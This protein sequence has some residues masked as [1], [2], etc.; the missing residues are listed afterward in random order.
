MKER[1]YGFL[2]RLERHTKVDMVYLSSG[3]FWSAIATVWGALI[4]LSTAAALANFLPKETYGTYQYVLTAATVIGILALPGTKTSISYAAARG[5]DGSFLDSV[6]AKIRWGFLAALVSFLLAAYYLYRGNELLA[7]SF[8]I[9]GAFMPYWE[10]F[11]SYVPYLQGKKRFKEMTLYEMAVQLA[12]ASAIVL[13]IAFTDSLL[14]LTLAFF[15]SYTF[16]RLFFYERAIRNIPPNTE[17]DPE[18]LSYGKHLSVMGILG[19]IA[20]NVDKFLLWQFL[21]PVAVAVYAFALAIPLRGVSTFTSVNRLYFP[22][23]AERPLTEVRA[24]VQGRIGLLLVLTTLTAAL[25]ALLAPFIF[26]IIFPAYMDAVPYTQLAAVLIALQPF[27][28]FATILSAHA[29]TKALY[30]Y[31]SAIPLVQ[32][33]LLLV[34]VPWFGLTGALAA[35]IAAQVCESALAVYLVYRS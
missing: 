10:A 26:S 22:K 35:L 6:R 21:G 18:V 7:A 17:R 31:S 3:S 29:R 25:Y 13:V 1:T 14:L 15:G 23:F 24:S 4:A 16:A 12:N 5:F 27:S 32:I 34:L 9:V 2:R 20:S 33:A 19:T 11:G 30:T 8:A 28:L